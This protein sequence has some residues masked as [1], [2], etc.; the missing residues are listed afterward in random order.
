MFDLNNRDEELASDL[1]YY[2]ICISAI[3]EHSP[4]AQVFC[5]MNKMDVVAQDQRKQVIFNAIISS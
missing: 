1:K 4:S 2:Q 5:L 3:Y